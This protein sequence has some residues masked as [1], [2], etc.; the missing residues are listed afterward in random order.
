MHHKKNI[1]SVIFLILLQLL[2]T[3][4]YAMQIH[5]PEYYLKLN[6]QACPRFVD[7]NGIEVERNLDAQSSSAEIPINHWI[8]NGENTIS[9]HYGPEDFVKARINEHSTCNFAVWVKGTLGGRDVNF[10]VADLDY[11]PNYNL[12]EKERHKNSSPAGHYKLE[13]NQTVLST[14]PADF[15]IGEVQ[16]GSGEFESVAGRIYRTFTA[17][18][19]FPE[20]AFFSAEHLSY[21]PSTDDGYEAMKNKLWPMVLELWKLFE[22]QDMEKILPLFEA[23]SKEID[24]AYYHEP[25]YTLKSLEADLKNVYTQKYPLDRRAEDEMQLVVSYNEKL[26]TLVNAATRN[27]TVIFYVKESDSVIFFDIVWMKKDGKWI[28]AR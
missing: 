11:N 24:I 21:Y 12:P 28:V 13:N 4:V 15:E 20:W 2:F 10:K 16:I 25:G 22:T 8:R 17:N 7:I 6:M 19:P 1:H 23:R 26:V 27:G 5:E 3:K 18:V 9:F 14:S